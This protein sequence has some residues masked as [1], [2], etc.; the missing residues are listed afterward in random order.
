MS[1]QSGGEVSLSVDQRFGQ[2]VSDIRTMARG[3]SQRQMAE[4]LHK[5]GMPAD[6]PAVSRIEKG[7]RSVRISE[8]EIIAKVL[9]VRMADLLQ[10]EVSPADQLGHLVDDATRTLHR[11]AQFI[12][13][14]G[15]DLQLVIGHLRSHPELMAI[16]ST[17]LNDPADYL[18]HMARSIGSWSVQSAHS[19]LDPETRMQLRAVVLELFAVAVPPPGYDVNA[20]EAGSVAPPEGMTPEEWREYRDAVRAQLPEASDQE[21]RDGYERGEAEWQKMRQMTAGELM[22]DN[23]MQVHGS[24]PPPP[25]REGGGESRL[26]KQSRRPG[27][28]ESSEA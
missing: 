21:I 2:Q 12:A 26:A 22:D 1:K 23:A 16:I 9:G 8:V 17:E 25:L 13:Q 28:D 27:S 14:G 20:A 15:H 10:D 4:E 5:L 18:P 19:E 7:Q 24:V 11:L 3:M 6:A